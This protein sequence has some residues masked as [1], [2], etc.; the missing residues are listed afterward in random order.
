MSVCS[1]ALPVCP[2][3]V[4]I[5]N[6][7]KLPHIVQQMC[8][9]ATPKATVTLTNLPEVIAFVKVAELNPHLA[10]AVRQLT[11]VI[12]PCTLVVYDAR[13]T[14]CPTMRSI[15]RLVPKVTDL[16]LSLPKG[17]PP[18]IFFQVY[19]PD[20]CFFKTD[21]PH[22]K[23]RQFVDNHSTLSILVLGPCGNAGQCALSD[24]DLERA[25]TVECDA[26]CVGAVARKGL[27]HLAAQNDTTAYSIPLIFRKLSCV[28]PELY[29]LTVDFFPADTDILLSIALVAPRVRKLKLLEK[30]VHVGRRISSRRAFNDHLTWHRH[31]RKLPNLE[32]FALRTAAPLVSRGGD[33]NLERRMVVGWACGMRKRGTQPLVGYKGHPSLYHVRLWYGRTI[34]TSAL[35]KWFKDAGQWV[36]LST[37]ITGSGLAD[38]DF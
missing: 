26:R 22:D 27:V 19:F 29:S 8:A 31:L 32:E 23:I 3:S 14:Y 36:R 11:I 10:D 21:L 18:D 13:V 24:L 30:S 2:A 1:V 6:W 5:Y 28:M 38:V 12:R 20:L 37:P 17:T 9:R 15:L 25:T 34:Q 7:V 33:Y 16:T 4:N 35:S